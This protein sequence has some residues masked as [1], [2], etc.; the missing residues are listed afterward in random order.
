MSRISNEY[1]AFEITTLP[2][3]SQVAV[4]HGFVV[5]EHKRGQG[6]GHELKSIQNYELGE[7]HYDFAVCTVA[8]GNA[9]QKKVL[10]KAGW[11]YLTHF[12][13]TRSSEITELWGFQPAP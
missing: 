9:A 13:N 1:G 8:A 2:G 11:A 4:C 5:P 6:F 10:T 12:R 3:Q 7:L